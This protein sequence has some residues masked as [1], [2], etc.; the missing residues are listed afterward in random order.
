[1]PLPPYVEFGG[2][3]AGPAP[4]LT[5]GGRLRALTL[6]ADR[7]RLDEI[8]HRTLT[9]P[10]GGKVEYRALGEH[11]IL[12]LGGFGAVRCT[13]PPYDTWGTVREVQASFWVP[14]VGGH[15]EH[16]LFVADRFG[17]T[18]PYVIV[19]NPMSYVGGRDVYGYAKS[20][21]RFTPE[22]GIGEHA[23]VLVYGGDFTT[24]STASWLPFLEVQALGPTAGKPGPAMHGALEV[25]A[26]L[27]D[28]LL[29]AVQHHEDLMIGGFK[30]LAQAAG[31]LAQGRAHQIFLKQFRDAADGTRACYQAVVEGPVTVHDVH[32]TPTGRDWRVTIHPLDSH[33]IGKELG[34]V[35]QTCASAYD[36][37]ID[38][39]VEDGVEV[40]P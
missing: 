34:L 9:G 6:K 40:A 23:E 4:F 20:Q 14:V 33:P 28:D 31:D 22:D 10:A 13:R 12:Q 35:S 8:V 19:D 39:T 30:L 38:F 2:R 15:E 29:H 16:G 36:V 27:H 37:E 7:D 25:A 17:M 5:T 3:V 24:T 1:M 11:V 18:A 26:A 21:G 32:V